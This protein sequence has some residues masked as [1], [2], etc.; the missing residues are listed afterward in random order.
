[1]EIVVE[2]VKEMGCHLYNLVSSAA[3][4]LELD[5][6]LARTTVWSAYGASAVILHQ[7]RDKEKSCEESN[8]KAEIG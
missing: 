8:P 4:Y 2:T 7:Y 1:M 6:T 5:W 3:P